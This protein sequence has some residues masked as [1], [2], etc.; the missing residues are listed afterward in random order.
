MN[1]VGTDKDSLA[2][3]VDPGAAAPGGTVHT[4]AKPNPQVDEARSFQADE[5]AKTSAQDDRVDSDD[6]TFDP[7]ATRP[8]SW[9]HPDPARR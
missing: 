2:S 7:E 6:E 1:N 8:S 4:G 5:G 9:F 3:G